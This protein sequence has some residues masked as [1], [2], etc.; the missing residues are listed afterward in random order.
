M[1]RW[2]RNFRV[3][4]DQK[5]DYEMAAQFPIGT[6]TW[7]FVGGR[8]FPVARTTVPARFHFTVATSFKK[9]K[10]MIDAGK[11]GLSETDFAALRA[12]FPDAVGKAEPGKFTIPS[13]R[14]F[15]LPLVPEG[16]VV[17]ITPE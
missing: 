14:E 11:D 3:F 17:D 15:T 10:R 4:A 2:R 12:K 5:G 16:T 7:Q 1:C 9:G 8:W 13:V 6:S